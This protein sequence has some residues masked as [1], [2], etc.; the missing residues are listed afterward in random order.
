MRKIYDYDGEHYEAIKQ[1]QQQADRCNVGKDFTIKPI[2][3]VNAAQ[4]EDGYSWTHSTVVEHATS[5]HNKRSYKICVMKRGHFI[6]TIAYHMKQ[7]K[8][9]Q[10]SIYIMK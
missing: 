2:G 4:R 1:R 9:P 3:S 8:Y 10:N 5:Q 6:T 7:T